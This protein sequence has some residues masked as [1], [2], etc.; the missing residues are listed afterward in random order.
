MSDVLFSRA[1]RAAG[2]T[3][4]CGHLV[5]TLQQKLENGG[6]PVG[7]IDGIYGSDTEGAVSDWQGEVGQPV[8]GKLTEAEWTLL[9]GQAAPDIFDRCL[10]I[11]GRFEGHGF[12][13]AAGNFDGAGITWGIIG[14]TLKHGE[15]S[16]IVAQLD[17]MDTSIVDSAF[18]SLASELRDKLS[19]SPSRQEKWAD[20]I[21]VG[22]RKHNLEP[23]W[24]DAFNRLGGTPEAQ[25]IQVDRA[26]TKYWSR[27]ERDSQSLGLSSKLGLALCFDVAVQNGG[28]SADEA[29]LYSERLARLG[30]VDP[31]QKRRVLAETIA[32]TSNPRWRE[33]VLS[34]KL[35]LASGIGTVHGERFSTPNWGLS[36][37]TGPE[38]EPA[39]V[40]ASSATSFDLFFKSLGLRHFKSGEFLFLGD[41]H[42][43]PE[44]AAFGLNH[45]P[46]AELW[47]N[48]APT[49]RILDELRERLDAP[50]ILSS[51][52]RSPMY[53][54]A[55]GGVPDSQH[56]AFCA[57]DFVVRSASSPSDWAAVLKQLRADGLFRGGIGVYN[58]FVHVDTRGENLDW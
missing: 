34:R 56:T 6:F 11:T 43:D 3:Y 28:V 55:I 26:R 18:G 45:P 42:R 8:T 41:A 52:Y 9:T 58:T 25:T 19:K 22:A 47:N 2:F 27:A 21:S 7:K 44:S 31:A 14:F 10:Q 13:K 46:P 32:D 29:D 4:A 53:N 20:S 33:D 50:I 36:G 30:A 23:E 16:A 40:P 5:E 35:T 1:E 15:I 39:Q 12:R 57:A 17:S 37:V 49:A 48:I 54:A 24:R 51:V 38:A